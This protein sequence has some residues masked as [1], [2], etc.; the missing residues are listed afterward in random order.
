M[1][2][3]EQ[4]TECT[5]FEIWNKGTDD[6][7]NVIFTVENEHT[8]RIIVWNSFPVLPKGHKQLVRTPISIDKISSAWV[9][10]KREY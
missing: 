4:G 8:R 7:H 6:A 9:T 1:S 10:C 3:I 2:V 5:E